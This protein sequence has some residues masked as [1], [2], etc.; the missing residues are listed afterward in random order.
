LV[1]ISTVSITK[2]YKS[3]KLFVTVL[4]NGKID[5]C[6]SILN[7]AKKHIRWL[8]AKRISIKRVPQLLFLKN[9]IT[10]NL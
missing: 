1:T 8:L 5:S 6:L 3:V 2:D 9:D 4:E 10:I 7:N